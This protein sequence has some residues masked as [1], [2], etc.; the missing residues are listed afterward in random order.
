MANRHSTDVRTCSDCKQPA[1][2]GRARCERHFVAATERV[3]RWR[4]LNPER[5]ALHRKNG[6]AK[7]CEAVKER[8]RKWSAANRTRKSATS[9]A[10]AKANQDK[11]LNSRVKRFGLT[12][13]GY[14]D[15]LKAQ[16]NRCAICLTDKPGGRGRFAVD[17][18]HKAEADGSMVVR[19]LLC[20]SCNSALGNFLDSPDS[21]RRAAEYIESGG[22]GNRKKRSN[23]AER[24]GG[25]KSL[26]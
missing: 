12:A 9:A 15:L 7:N 20:M 11:V 3:N 1:M 22:F 5:L 16:N 6:Y 26:V 2:A 19:G 4:A 13:E 14:N 21:M 24:V 17:H 18:D 23:E 8:T 10:W 25:V